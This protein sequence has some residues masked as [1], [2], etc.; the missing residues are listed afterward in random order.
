[1]RVQGPPDDAGDVGLVYIHR[2]DSE[3]IGETKGVG[4]RAN[5]EV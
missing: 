5:S 3:W 2:N 1:M 4:A